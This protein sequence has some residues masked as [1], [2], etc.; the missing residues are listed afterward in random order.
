MDSEIRLYLQHVRALA[1]ERGI[2][3]TPAQLRTALCDV[4]RVVMKELGIGLP[5]IAGQLRMWDEVPPPP[6]YPALFDD[7]REVRQ[8]KEVAETYHNITLRIVYA[9]FAPWG[10][11][12][13]KLE[14]LRCPRVRRLYNYSGST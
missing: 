8:F 3:M 4:D 10:R 11:P 9:H 13:W 5:E 1:A 7:L 6:P 12:Y 2:E 14:V